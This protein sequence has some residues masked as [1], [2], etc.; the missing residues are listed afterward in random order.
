MAGAVHDAVYQL[1]EEP[2]P[3]TQINIAFLNEFNGTHS[4]GLLLL[5]EEAWE[6]ADEC[7]RIEMLAKGFIRQWIGGLITIDKIEDF[8]FQVRLQ[9]SIFFIVLF[10][11]KIS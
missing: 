1:M 2:L 11:R 4:T 3:F 5:S 7:H 10:F 9:Y 8:C 6:E